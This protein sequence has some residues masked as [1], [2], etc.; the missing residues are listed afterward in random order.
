VTPAKLCTSLIVSLATAFKYGAM[1]QP[2][3]WEECSLKC[4]GD[5]SVCG[6]PVRCLDM[7]MGMGTSSDKS[8][9]LSIC[10]NCCTDTRIERASASFG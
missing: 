5:G 6:S 2:A 4:D 8:A 3:S 7:T 10:T 1:L 9:S